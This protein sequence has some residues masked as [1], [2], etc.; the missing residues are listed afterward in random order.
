MSELLSD[1]ADVMNSLL[2]AL[3]DPGQITPRAPLEALPSWQRRAVIQHAAP[4]IAAAEKRRLLAVIDAFECPCGEADCSGRDTLSA[5]TAV[6]AEENEDTAVGSQDAIGSR[7]RGS[8]VD[9]TPDCGGPR[10]PPGAAEMWFCDAH[11][12]FHA[13]PGGEGSDGI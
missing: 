6:L 4:F 3:C 7:M 2:R 12:E 10:K 9:P 13:P 1:N 8:S 11:R 5:L